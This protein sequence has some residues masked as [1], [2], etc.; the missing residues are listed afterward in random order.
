MR[1]YSILSASMVISYFVTCNAATSSD[2]T[3][4]SRMESP[5]LV[6]SLGA[7]VTA[8]PSTEDFFESEKKACKSEDFI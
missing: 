2:Q 5:V 8:M 3:K 7:A 1:L 4:L 6:H